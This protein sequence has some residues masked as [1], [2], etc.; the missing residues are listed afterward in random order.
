MRREQP[1]LGDNIV[2][3]ADL[4]K[5][6]GMCIQWDRLELQAALGHEMFLPPPVH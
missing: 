5:E 2:Q 1:D 3:G 6:E 4:P